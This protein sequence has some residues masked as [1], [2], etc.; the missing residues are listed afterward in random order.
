[1]EVG[2]GGGG[3]RP[4]HVSLGKTVVRRARSGGRTVPGSRKWVVR[5][6]ERNL[7]R[8]YVSLL[9]TENVVP[10][11]SIRKLDKW[12]EWDPRKGVGTEM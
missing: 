8:R 7:D 10:Q 5:V 4:S 1:M 12:M 11:L 3:S 6:W 9:G 2:E